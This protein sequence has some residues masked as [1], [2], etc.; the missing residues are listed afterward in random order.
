MSLT[1]NEIIFV[2][3]RVFMII[4]L[5]SIALYYFLKKR[6]CDLCALTK[7]RAPQDGINVSV[8]CKF[9]FPRHLLHY[10]YFNKSVRFHWRVDNRRRH[11]T[12]A[13]GAC[14]DACLM[15]VFVLLRHRHAN[16]IPTRRARLINRF[17]WRH[18]VCCV[19]LHIGFTASSHGR[20]G[21]S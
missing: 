8:A 17:Y 12:I 9:W 11:W 1:T 19:F 2:C 14:S 10:A 16:I 18:A 5:I 21:W 20:C 3:I 6:N 4:F 13:T 7:N 15:N